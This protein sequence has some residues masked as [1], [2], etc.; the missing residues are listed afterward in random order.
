MVWGCARQIASCQ[1]AFRYFLK[2]LENQL[3][4]LVM[5]AE[6]ML[7][8][9]LLYGEADTQQEVIGMRHCRPLRFLFVTS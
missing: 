9:L 6:P 3:S 8:L 4:L 2:S 7:P 1:F 5:V